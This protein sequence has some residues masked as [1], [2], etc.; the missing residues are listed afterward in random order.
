MRLSKGA[1]ERDGGVDW[2]GGRRD[3]GGLHGVAWDGG[4]GV[5]GKP[6]EKLRSNGSG[7]RKKCKLL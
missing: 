1:I 3:E 4:G 7:E 5:G 2:V 6:G